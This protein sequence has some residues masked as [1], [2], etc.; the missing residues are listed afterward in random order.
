M[1]SNILP[2]RDNAFKVMGEKG[3]YELLIDEKS[4]SYSWDEE[5][6]KETRSY[7]IGSDVHDR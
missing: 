5:V 2:T 3:D 1:Q 7:C 6:Q 4:I